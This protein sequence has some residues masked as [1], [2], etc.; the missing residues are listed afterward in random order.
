MKVSATRAPLRVLKNKEFFRWGMA[1]FKA[2][3]HRLCRVPDYVASGSRRTLIVRAA[4]LAV[5]VP[6]PRI[7]LTRF[8]GVFAPASRLRARPSRPP[9]AAAAAQ[10]NLRA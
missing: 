3:S 6:P 9:P 5:L 10:R 4:R 2:R 8:H 1:F 7:H